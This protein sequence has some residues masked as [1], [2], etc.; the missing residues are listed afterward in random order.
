MK[1]IFFS[2]LSLVS[3][4]TFAQIGINTQIPQASFH[5]DGAKNNP[6]TGI[7]SV[8]QQ[9]D[10]MVVT[11][12]GNMGIGTITPT[13]KLEVKSATANTSGLKF[14][15]LNSAT[16][17]AAG[18]TLGVDASGNVITVNGNSFSPAFGRAVLANTVNI[19]AAGAQ[20]DLVT[21]TL[22][23]AG[24]YLITYSIR[25]EIQVTGSSGYLVGFLSTAPS[26]GNLIPNTEI[27]VVTSKDASREV[28]GGTGTGSL[29]VTVTGPTT[30]YAGIRS[31]GLAGIVFNNADGRTS[32]TY[33][34]V[35]P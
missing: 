33:V 17:V 1:K 35:T 31:V 29:V 18:A 22:P 6:P 2:V 8:A 5:V 15:N 20:Y 3:L 10:D 34:K 21:F 26:A 28:I 4:A 27:L 25:G 24:T 23:S 12:S 9:S 19:P 30:Y 11:S 16:P 13:S 14:S 32:V 7:P